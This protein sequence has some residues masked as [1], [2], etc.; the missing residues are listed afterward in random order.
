MGG[1]WFNV[2]QFGPFQCN[3]WDLPPDSH[4][5]KRW[6]PVPAVETEKKKWKVQLETFFSFLERLFLD[7]IF[8]RF[9]VVWPACE[10]SENQGKLYELWKSTMLVQGRYFHAFIKKNIRAICPFY[11]IWKSRP[12]LPCYDVEKGGNFQSRKKSCSCKYFLTA[13]IV[14]TSGLYSI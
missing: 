3:D 10:N 9:C 5:W 12:F 14:S 11:G 1:R 2:L 13:S 8:V 7:L 4:W 6:A